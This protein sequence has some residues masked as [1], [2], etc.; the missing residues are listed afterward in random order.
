VGPNGGGKST[1]FKVL[2]TLLEGDGEVSL[3]GKT[4]RE[5][6][7]SIRR[8]IGVVFQSPA[9][10]DMLTVY[11][12]LIHQGQL[13]SIKG[14]LLRD[15]ANEM[16]QRLR[17]SDRK[18]HRVESLSG[19]LKRRLDLARA[20]MHQPRLLLLDEP[21]TGLD[22]LMRHEI[23]SYIRL[24][25]E[26]ERVTVLVT[27]HLLEEA[28]HC[29]RIALLDRGK[30][31]VEGN[32][33]DLRSAMGGQIISIQAKNPQRLKENIEKTF[34]DTVTVVDQEVRLNTSTGAQLV[35]PLMH[36]FSDEIDTISLGKPTLEDLFIQKA[37]RFWSGAEA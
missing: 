37:G 4:I 36:A 2:S 33:S 21:T 35:E 6:S 16:L 9:L 13:Y 3:F 5:N 28:E 14:R 15:R 27:T 18:S 31:I 34:S 11:E 19:G 12:T 25:R 17:I 10:D 30:I 22:P 20:L 26:S 32:P 7:A 24:L 1:L 29:D 23:W 8:S